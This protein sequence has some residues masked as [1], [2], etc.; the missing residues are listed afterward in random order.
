MGKLWLYHKNSFDNDLF[1]LVPNHFGMFSIDLAVGPLTFELTSQDFLK[2]KLMDIAIKLFVIFVQRV[3]C[4]MNKRVIVA[5][6][7]II[8]FS[9]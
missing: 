3:I 6:S 7:M 5:L 9:S 4:K 2:S 8:F 1:Y